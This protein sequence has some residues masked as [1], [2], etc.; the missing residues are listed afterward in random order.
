MSEIRKGNQ[1]WSLEKLEEQEQEIKAF[2]L[3]FENRDERWMQK[4]DYISKVRTGL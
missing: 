3:K 4:Y 2:L 1:K